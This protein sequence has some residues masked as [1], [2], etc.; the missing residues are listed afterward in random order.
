MQILGLRSVPSSIRSVQKKTSD[1]LVFEFVNI[2]ETQV[3]F[4]LLLVIDVIKHVDVYLGF[5]RRIKPKGIV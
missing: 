3:Q 4:D 5:L 2:L 1:R